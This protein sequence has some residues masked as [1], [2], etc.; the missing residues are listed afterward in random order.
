MNKRSK[1]ERVC[2]ILYLA[3]LLKNY[4]VQPGQYLNLYISEFPAINELKTIFKS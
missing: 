4:P 1:H 3:K 2:M